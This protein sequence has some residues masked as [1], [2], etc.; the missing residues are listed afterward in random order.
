MAKQATGQ[1]L[2]SAER[3][4]DVLEAFTI[5]EPSLSVADVSAKLDLAASTVR[6]LLNALERHG[7]VRVD[8]RTGQFAPHYQVVRLAAIALQ[9]NDL[10]STSSRSLDALRDQ[11]D[12][13]VQL[14]VLSG[15]DIVF[16]DRR[17]S[18]NLIKIFSPIGHRDVAWGGRA[19]GKVLLA[20]LAEDE[21]AAMLPAPSD[22][23][24]VGPNATPTPAAFLTSLHEVRDLG[25]AINDEET[26]RDVWA[27][28]APIRDHT[29]NVVAAVNVPVLKSRA[30]DPG[31]VAEL[32][33]ATTSAACEIS[34]NL[35]YFEE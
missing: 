1:P 11:T 34:A 10:I 24:A 15:S 22:W 32:I 28:A 21:V 7:F 3:M 5:A 20:W 27:V 35:S 13:A 33:A 4:L 26:E 19:S 29:G 30:T 8:P 14:T 16:V 2:R 12:E 23:P 18:S 17:E 25:Y 6:R 31:R 9:G